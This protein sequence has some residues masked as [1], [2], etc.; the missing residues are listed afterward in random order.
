MTEAA[1]I[2]LGEHRIG[3]SAACFVIAEAGVNHN[4]DLDLAR[5]LIDAAAAAGADAVKFQTFS[6][7]RIATR[8]APKAAYQ[9]RTTSAGESQYAML[10]RLELSE[11]AHRILMDH[12]RARGIMFLSSPFDERS[13]DLLESLGVAG[14][15]IP[16]GEITN[17]PFLA[18]V[19][20]KQRP[21]IMSSGMSDLTEVVA[22]VETCAAT[23]NRDI[24]LLHCLSDYP[25]DPAETNLRAMATMAEA[26]SLPV[27]FSDHTDGTAITL[28]AVALGACAIEKHFTLDRNLPGPD[29]LASLEPD[30]LTAMMQQIRAVESA[31]GDGRKRPQPS[32]LTT[33]AVAR[34]SLVAA[35]DL[36]SG[37]TL[38]AADLA[39]LR[40]G[41]GLSPALTGQ[42]IGRRTRRRIRT[43]TPLVW[44]MLD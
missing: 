39:A 11:K 18:H 19:A 8:D 31:L 38:A 29:H 33:R 40:P 21:L 13:A 2:A 9:K 15:K 22:A 1:A 44:E 16:S 25:A 42:V 41:T 37:V 32:E 12:C 26:C 6:A 10:R 23:G 20:A 3:G 36:P 7:E 34:K 17:L 35:R 4:G 5:R 30:A 27:G 28:A 14:F 24:V 43:G